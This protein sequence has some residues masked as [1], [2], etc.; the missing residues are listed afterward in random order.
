MLNTKDA[1]ILVGVT[2]PGDYYISYHTDPT[3]AQTSSTS[4]PIPKDTDYLVTNSQ[5]VFVIVENISNVDCNAVS[6]DSA[7]STFTSFE[8]IVDALSLIHISEPTRPY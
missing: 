2:N 4:N 5:T 1:E 7:G 8:L 3:D 6:D